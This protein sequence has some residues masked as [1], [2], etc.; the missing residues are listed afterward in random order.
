MILELLDVLHDDDTDAVAALLDALDRARN[1]PAKVAR[2]LRS[3][4][5]PP[6][7]LEK[8]LQSGENQARPMCLPFR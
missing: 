3:T 1:D 2:M 8:C 7:A 6:L 5:L 4:G